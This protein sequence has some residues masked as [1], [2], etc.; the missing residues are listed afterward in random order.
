VEAPADGGTLDTRHLKATVLYYV[1]PPRYTKKWTDWSTQTVSTSSLTDWTIGDRGLWLETFIYATSSYNDTLASD[2]P[3]VK[4]I[5]IERNGV[6]VLA[7]GAIPNIL[8][9]LID[10]TNVADDD[11]LYMCLSQGPNDY[12]DLCPRLSGLTKFRI[13][14][15]VADAVI[16]AFSTIT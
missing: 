1:T 2:A 16:A 6:D 12:F 11:Y 15:G 10:T 4:E 3:S 9:C 5:E 14:G 13:L 8:G 7:S